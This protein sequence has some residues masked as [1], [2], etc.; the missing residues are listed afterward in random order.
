MGRIDFVLVR[1]KKGQETNCATCGEPL[2]V[3]DKAY[4]SKATKDKYCSKH[5]LEYSDSKPHAVSKTK[6]DNKAKKRYWRKCVGMEQWES[7]N[8]GDFLFISVWG[9]RVVK[10]LGN[11]HFVLTGT[12]PKTLYEGKDDK[13]AL[14]FARKYVSTHTDRLV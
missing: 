5:C 1:I 12:T 13:D 4:V 6:F 2:L 7:V 14:R 9:S 3:G 8:H 10:R 11:Y